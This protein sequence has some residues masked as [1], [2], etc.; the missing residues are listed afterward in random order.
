MAVPFIARLPQYIYSLAPDGIF[1]NL[2]AESS[3]S[4]TAQGQDV[5]IACVTQFPYSGSVKLTVS[6]DLPVEMNLRLRIPS[7]GTGDLPILLNGRSIAMGKAGTYV[8]LNRKWTNGD[9]VSFELTF[10][11]RLTRYIGADQDPTYPR[12]ALEYG[13]LLMAL[14][15]ASDLDATERDLPSRLVPSPETALHFAVAGKA[16][17]VFVPYFEVKL[18]PFTCFPTL[19]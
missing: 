6:T 17:A 9:V 2:F 4:W 14:L 12:Y 5:S 16:D 10:A 15:G 19:R 13:P 7:W 11:F 1:V 8:S 18:E 3:I